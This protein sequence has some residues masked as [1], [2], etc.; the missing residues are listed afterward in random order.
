MIEFRNDIPLSDK[1]TFRIGGSARRYVEPSDTE[2]ILS[3]IRRAHKE[4][5]PLLVLGRG[6][7]ILVSDCGW[8]GLV[9][10]LSL[11]TSMDWNG[12]S[13]TAQA[14]VLLDAV[15]REA[16]RRKFAGME[17]LS[18]IPGSVG[19]AVIMNAGAFETCIADTLQEATYLDSSS[20]HVAVAG[21]KE[22]ELGYRSSALQ[23]KS[24]VVLSARF[25]L[26]PGDGETL[27][28]ARCRVLE[29]RRNKQPLDLPN[30]G[31]VFKRPAGG[32]AGALIERAG[33]KGLRHGNAEISLKHAN[34]I[35]NLGG[36]TAADVRH[37]IVEAQRRVYE[38]S[39]VLLEPEVVF[40]GEFE[41]ELFNPG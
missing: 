14:G 4:G 34:F 26:K 11:F 20:Y 8:P 7:N 24:A 29:K 6:S 21:K 1:T 27:K 30:C 28:E 2:E 39:G 23:K 19:G 15:V 18:G 5:L 35:V 31:S 37:L 41:E 40:A 3:A 13:V 22:L 9:I 25:L 33:L 32:F 38:R 12:N 17:G 16:V 10:N 36:A